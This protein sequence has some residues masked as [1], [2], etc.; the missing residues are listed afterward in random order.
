MPEST[1]GWMECGNGYGLQFTVATDWER[2]VWETWG[3]REESSGNS[4]RERVWIHKANKNKRQKTRQTRQIDIQDANI[5]Q[6][7][8]W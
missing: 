2:D 3:K 6:D 5:R 1:V 7:F 8:D 4:P